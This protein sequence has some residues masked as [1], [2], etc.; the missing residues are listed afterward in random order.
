MEDNQRA[1]SYCSKAF[2][3]RGI[4]THETACIWKSSQYEHIALYEAQY[5]EQMQYVFQESEEPIHSLV[6]EFEHFGEDRVPIAEYHP[7]S[8]HESKQEPFEVYSVH[9]HF[10]EVDIPSDSMPWHLYHSELDF[11]LAETVLEAALNKVPEINVYYT[12]DILQD[13]LLAPHL[14]WDAQ[15]LFRCKGSASE[16]FYTEPWTGNAFWEV[17]LALPIDG[18]PLCYIIYADK[19]HLSSFSTVQGYPVIVR[20][21]NLPAYIH[22]GQG[23]GG[24]R[25]IGWLPI[26][27]SKISAQVQPPSSNTAPQHVFP[28]I[29]ILSADYEEQLCTSVWSQDLY[30]EAEKLTSVLSQNAFLK[31]YGLFHEECLLEHQELQHSLGPL[32]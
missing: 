3:L 8:C 16:Q 25:V 5:R 10:T 15:K 13:P 30:N 6:N 7:S 28:T 24:G 22:N 12:L 11:E 17:Q 31:P 29:M 2:K 20:L 32:F 21:E 4:K 1:C 9:K 23:V 27:K 19:T 14:V 18:K 26:D